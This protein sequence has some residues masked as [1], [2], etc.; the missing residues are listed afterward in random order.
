M[1]EIHRSHTNARI[2]KVVCHGDY[3]YL[4][5]QTAAGGENAGADIT[6]QTVETLSRIDALLAEVDSDRSRILSAT[7]YLRDMNDFA[8]MNVTWEAWITPDNAP[9]RTTVEAR[10]ALPSLLVEVTVIA[11]RR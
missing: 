5:G 2:S 11:A 10:L 4:C 3:I 6:T 1:T 7:V 8:A 9:A